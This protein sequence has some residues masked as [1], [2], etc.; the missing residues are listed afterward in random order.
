MVTTSV[1]FG[2]QFLSFFDLGSQQL[3]KMIS[4]LLRTCQR[5]KD[6]PGT[7]ILTWNNCPE[8]LSSLGEAFLS[9][10]FGGGKF[11]DCVDLVFDA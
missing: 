2:H 11:V 10:R 7:W 9:S 8:V 5:G 6:P 3:P 4:I 1:C